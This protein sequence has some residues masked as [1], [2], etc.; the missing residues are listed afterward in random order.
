MKSTVAQ[1]FS[2]ALKSYDEFAMPQAKLAQ[3]LVDLLLDHADL[4]EKDATSNSI[5]KVL[6]IGCGTGFLTKALL[7]KTN[8]N[9]YV[10][11]DIVDQCAEVVAT[12]GKQLDTQT[13]FL[14]GNIEELTLPT[15]VDLICSASTFQWLKN[16]P[17]LVQSISQSLNNNG[18]LAISSFSPDHFKE[19]NTSLAKANVKQATMAYLSVTEWESILQQDFEILSIKEVS[20]QMNFTNFRDLLIHLR[21][22]GVNGNRLESLQPAQIHRASSAYQDLSINNT[23][24]LSYQA[25]QLIARK[26]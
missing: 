5:N 1:S 18:Y 6:E 13:T 15:N 17:S 8:V 26:R 23:L 12:I 19:L 20:Q 2:K 3:S 11:N 21:K 25:I 4:Q 24:P 9:H 10:A 7:N 14:A 16:T 22:T